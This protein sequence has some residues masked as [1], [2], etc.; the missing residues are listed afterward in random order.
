MLIGIERTQSL[1]EGLADAIAR[2]GSHCDVDANVLVARVEAHRVVG[3][4]KH[5][6][7]DA[8]P[9][10]G[11]EEIVAAHDVG[12]QDRLPGSLD[13]EPAQVDHSIDPIHG[14]LDVLDPGKL[15]RHE[16]LIGAQISRFFD[17]AEPQLWIDR[18]EDLAQPR[19]DVASSAREQN[20]CHLE[21]PSCLLRDC[22][23]G[24]PWAPDQPW[25]P[26][27]IKNGYP[28]LFAVNVTISVSLQPLPVPPS[29]RATT[30]TPW[31]H[32]PLVATRGVAN[33]SH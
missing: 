31:E 14:P 16:I 7:L 2:I 19:A 25:I 26:Q 13:R 28:R 23:C 10:R 9:T 32:S 33:C 30:A 4:G 15:G 5:D 11:L 17:V 20:A 3:R 12:L 29:H 22:W 24:C 8:L 6:A 18:F 1:A 21:P 27:M